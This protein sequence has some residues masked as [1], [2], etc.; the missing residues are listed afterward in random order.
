MTTRR[1]FT[2]AV[3]LA[4]AARLA[5]WVGTMIAPIPNEALQPISPLHANSAIDLPFYL[6]S[7]EIY[8]IWVERFAATPVSGWG[9]LFREL[10]AYMRSNF[11]AGPLMA[12]LL[13]LFDYRAGN[14]LP[15]AIA[16]LATSCVLAIAWLRWLLRVQA[17]ASAFILFALMLGP[18]WLMLNVSTDLPFAALFALFFFIFFS[19][20]PD[21]ERYGWGIGVA[22]VATL[23]RPHGISLFLFMGLYAAFL[24]PGRTWA[25]KVILVGLLL[26]AGAAL[27]LLFTTYF[28]SYLRSS[29][30]IEYFGHA[31]AAYLY[32]I[33]PVLPDGLNQIAS[34]IALG[35]A[36]LLYLAGLRP[37]YGQT[38]LALVIVR[39]APG[40]IFLPGLLY[41]MLCA[42]WAY[43]LLLVAF[44][45]PVALGAAQ[46]RYLLAVTPLIVLFAT[47]A[48]HEM[49][50]AFTRRRPVFPPLPLESRA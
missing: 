40:L 46:D 4:V 48:G 49:L 26:L 18:L 1:V 28:E 16:Y 13:A 32:G 38:P 45:A 39:A 23:L 2:I 7:R 30:N 47:R 33:F 22:I 34:W 8:G 6:Y 27:L 41:G 25:Q 44:F 24:S 31:S 36:K 42:P 43:R 37:S 20:R 11:I 50:G 14:T 15:L 19:E 17:G 3:A 9:T 35:L 21:R 10:L 5:L 29:A 12:G